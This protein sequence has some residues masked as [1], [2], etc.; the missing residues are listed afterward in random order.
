MSNQK[1]LEGN[2]NKL[3]GQVKDRWGQ[4]TDTELDR[5]AGRR[6]QLIGSLQEKYG[7][8]AQRAE[9]EIDRMMSDYNTK[10][11]RVADRYLPSE[12][13]HAV[14]D[15]PWMSVAISFGIGLLLGVLLKPSR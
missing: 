13:S 7:Y 2:W 8:S 10:M 4:L 14:T 3:R 12:L 6:D 15:Y 11:Q 1:V 9:E 5:I